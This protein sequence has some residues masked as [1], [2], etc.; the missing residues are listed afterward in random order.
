MFDEMKQVDATI[1]TIAALLGARGGKSRSPKKLKA[2]RENARKA[3]AAR[4]LKAKK[5]ATA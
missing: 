5:L 4:M 1:S 3:T 2:V